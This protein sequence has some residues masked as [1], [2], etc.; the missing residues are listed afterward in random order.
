MLK[1]L[2][3]PLVEHAPAS[4]AIAYVVEHV[5]SRIRRRLIGAVHNHSIEPLSLVPCQTDH[6]VAIVTHKQ[7]GRP[8]DQTITGQRKGVGRECWNAV[9]ERHRGG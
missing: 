2:E 5:L 4:T 6:L 9:S 8:H 7:I 1:F 3:R